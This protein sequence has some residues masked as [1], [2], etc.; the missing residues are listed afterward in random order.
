MSVT[1]QNCIELT[2]QIELVS[3]AQPFLDLSHTVLQ[4][5]CVHLKN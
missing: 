1:S 4:E 3:G 2:E 5:I